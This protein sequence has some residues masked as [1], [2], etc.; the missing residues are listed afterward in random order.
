MSSVPRILVAGAL[1]CAGLC[2]QP[3]EAAEETLFLDGV[4]VAVWRPNGSGRHPLI[5]FSH[6]LHGCSTQS[7]F[8]MQ[9]SADAGY[10]V[11]APDHRD[12]GCRGGADEPLQAPLRS[13]EEWSD[14]TYRDRADDVQR[15]V[16]AV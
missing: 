11:L 16:R 2:A 9:G 13:P 12:S 4:H 10:L 7:G 5:V 3:S 1:L 14:R 15:V 6:G 8:I